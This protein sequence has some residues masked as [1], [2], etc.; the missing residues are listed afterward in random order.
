MAHSGVVRDSKVVK[1]SRPAFEVTKDS[2]GIDQVLLSTPKGATAH[3]S[4][5]FNIQFNAI[6]IYNL[7]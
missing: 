2:N 7:F 3:V 5:G 6:M 1:D 4:I